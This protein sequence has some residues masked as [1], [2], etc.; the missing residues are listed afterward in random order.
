[1]SAPEITPELLR[2]VADWYDSGPDNLPFT[3]GQLRDTASRVEREQAETNRIDALVTI[4]F[5]AAYQPTGDDTMLDREGVARGIRAVLEE[6]RDAELPRSN[7]MSLGYGRI[8]TLEKGH[9][10]T[11]HR[12]L[13][14]SGIL[15]TWNDSPNGYGDPGADPAEEWRKPDFRWWSRL[16]EV[17]ADVRS[18]WSDTG[19]L[20]VRNGDGWLNT[21]W[22]TRPG[23]DSVGPFHASREGAK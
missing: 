6:E 22:N 4:F 9:R 18:V 13:S 21:E 16:R 2:A 12:A 1:M 14:D 10:G 5:R 20:I 19:D 23:P 8:C 17:P 7:C 3:V 15:H 11:L